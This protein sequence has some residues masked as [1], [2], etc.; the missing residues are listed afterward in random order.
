MLS[1]GEPFDL[2]LT[3]LGLP[4]A[5]DG[6]RL[7]DLAANK[8][9]GIKIVTMTGYNKDRVAGAMPVG[10]NRAHLRKP[11]KRAEF[12]RVMEMLFEKKAMSSESSE[13]AKY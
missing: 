3:D 12:K 2:L 8:L 4:G 13:G 5:M 6:D 10:P 11:F 7:A 1:S 9:P